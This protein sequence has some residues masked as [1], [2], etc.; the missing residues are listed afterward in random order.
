MKKR[1]LM[2]LLA[3]G[4]ISGATLA[5]CGSS[6][7][8][9]SSDSATKSST[10]DDKF[11][12]VMVTD[13][14]GVDDKSFNQSAWEGMQ[15]WGEENNKEE[16]T[17]GFKYLQSNEDSEFVTNLN[18]AVQAK[19][20]LVFGIGY[21]LKE[22]MTDVSGQNEDQHFVIIDDMIESP[23]VASVLFKDHEA[24][25]LAGVA[26]AESTESGQIGFIGGQESD[27]ISRFEA[28][29]VAGVKEIKPEIDVKVEYVGSFGD[30]ARGKQLAAA[31]YSSGIDIIYQAAGD[32]GNGVF[33]EAKDLMNADD[34]KK[35]WVIGV[36]RDQNDE[37]KFDTGNLTLASTLKGVGAA[38][39]DIS[40]EA[41]AGNFAGGEVVNYG[42]AEG[43]V[44]LTD[45]NLTDE[46]KEKVAEYKQKVIDGE[47][48]V[49]QKP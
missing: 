46:V 19:F 17:E 49:P 39:K 41:L 2:S 12:V 32:S 45:G 37:G 23:N 24:A 25:F 15:E 5:A 29:F 34:S 11:S 3:L 16:G 28:G 27:V 8:D 9:T 33:S 4:L 44:D 26:A 47:I 36:D 18:S 21:K 7:S 22:A 35:L 14:G 38:V 10:S 1:N 20:D 43:G 13:V 30:A 42:L 31:M 48:E 40:N 6:D